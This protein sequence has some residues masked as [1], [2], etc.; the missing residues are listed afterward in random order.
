MW[1]PSNTLSLKVLRFAEMAY[2][3]SRLIYMR[4]QMMRNLLVMGN[5]MMLLVCI[6][7][8]G[9]GLKPL[10]TDHKNQRPDY[11]FQPLGHRGGH[12]SF[13]SQRFDLD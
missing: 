1:E 12:Q 9:Y 7:N 3:V 11:E 2:L 10:L 4:N 5:M 8:F 13:V 6:C